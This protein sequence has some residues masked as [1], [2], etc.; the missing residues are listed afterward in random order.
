MAGWLKS[1]GS[2]VRSTGK[3]I[4]SLGLALQG[5]LGY[6]ETL[7][8]AQTVL[9][10]AGAKPAIADSVFIAPSASVIGNVTLGS[11]SSVWYGT[12]LRGDVNSISVGEKT[13][14]QDNVLVHVAKHNAAHQELP[15]R[16]GSSVTVGHGAVIHAATLGDR[17]VIGMGAVVM[18]GAVVEPESIVA[19]G[20]LVTP[21]TVVPSGQ[22]WAGSPARFLRD[23]APG[24]AE[25][26][27]AA[28]E[29][30]AR[31]AAH[32]SVSRAA[33]RGQGGVQENGPQGR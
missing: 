3:A 22:V 2:V 31:L 5:S 16:I 32:L 27:A 6:R 33:P 20:A 11:G 26:I 9:P 24:E 21:G 10:Y 15:T 4:D 14:I 29:D 30:Y 25:F 17:V 8:K 12:V 28:A 18:D 1:L 7:S 19:A 23:L 13:N